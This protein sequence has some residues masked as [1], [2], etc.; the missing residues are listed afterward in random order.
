MVAEQLANSFTKILPMIAF[1]ALFYF[2][3]IK[4]QVKKEKAARILRDNI[5]EGDDIITI[6]GIY[7]KIINIKDDVVTLEIG[8]DKM[9]IKVT[10]WSVGMLAK[11]NVKENPKE[12]TE[13]K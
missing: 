13:K 3:L 8:A 6:G 7:G 9:K 4:P 10:K 5:A 1:I 2:V 11:D 12:I